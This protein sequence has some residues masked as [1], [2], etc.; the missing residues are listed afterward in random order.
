MSV[1]TQS[2][3]QSLPLFLENKAYTA[4]FVISD[5]NTR[6]ACYPKI[7]EYLPKHTIVSV[8]P[9]EH[10]KTLETCQEIWSDMTNRNLDRHALVI[11]LGGGVIGDMG[12]FCAATYKRGVDFIQIPTTLLAQVDASVGGKLGIDFNGLKN[13]LGVFTLP[14]SVLIDPVFLETL[15]LREL[16]SGFAE[17]IKHCLIADADKWEEIKRKDLS[18]HDFLDLISH[19]VAIKKKI[20][21]EDPTEKGLRKILNFGH[22][23]GHAI[24]TY[25][26]NSKN[27]LF[28]GEAIAAGMICEAFLAFKLKKI[29]MQELVQIEEFLFTI[30]GKAAIEE[31]DID[32]IVELTAQDKK[33]LGKEVR[34]SLL[35]GI[36]NCSFDTVVSTKDMKAA[37]AYYVG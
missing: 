4:V 10:F 14:Q 3:A 9:G 19:S 23:L 12:G 2:I 7:K 13:H 18:E 22:T 25:F 36:G 1:I 29:T 24:E 16:R 27:R 21:A 31:T 37:L 20:V 34:F 32:A 33:N 17:V 5:Q 6:R 26:L 8:K 30:Y 28:H 11:N 15:P 35:E